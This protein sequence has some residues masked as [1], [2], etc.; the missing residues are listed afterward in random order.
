MT[1]KSLLIMER[2]FCA[3]IRS[4]ATREGKAG[5]G[6]GRTLPVKE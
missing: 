4:L 3:C 5:R 1:L 2:A 6:K